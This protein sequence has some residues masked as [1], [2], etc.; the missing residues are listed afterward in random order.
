MRGLQGNDKGK[1]AKLVGLRFFSRI[2]C[3]LFW[4]FQFP[5]GCDYTPIETIAS[6]IFRPSFR[7]PDGDDKNHHQSMSL[8]TFFEWRVF[9]FRLFTH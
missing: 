7:H 5:K 3:F 9:G 1:I 2:F 4:F 6:D 8:L